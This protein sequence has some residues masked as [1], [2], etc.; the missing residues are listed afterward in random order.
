M[1]GARAGFPRPIFFGKRAPLGGFEGSLYER[2]ACRASATVAGVLWPDGPNGGPS[3]CLLRSAFA[4]PTE[5][6]RRPRGGTAADIRRERP[7]GTHD[8]IR[9]AFTLHIGPQARDLTS[10]GNRYTQVCAARKVN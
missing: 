8:L 1:D 4:E 5:D 7:G 9:R 3:L 10:R 2:P 6:G